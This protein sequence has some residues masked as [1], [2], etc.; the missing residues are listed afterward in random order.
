MGCVS[1]KKNT[2][3]IFPKFTKYYSVYKSAR[4]RKTKGIV[5]DLFIGV[6]DNK[7]F[8]KTKL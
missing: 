7:H 4:V 8:D 6:P 2:Y 3:E 5:L 1:N